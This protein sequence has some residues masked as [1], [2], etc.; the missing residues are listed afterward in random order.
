MAVTAKAE[1]ERKHAVGGKPEVRCC[2]PTPFLRELSLYRVGYVGCVDT[3]C[4]T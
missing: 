3:T 1:E 2:P 4:P